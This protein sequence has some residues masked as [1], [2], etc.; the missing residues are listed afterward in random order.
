MALT[1]TPRSLTPENAQGSQVNGGGLSVSLTSVTLDAS[2]AANGVALSPQQMGFTNGVLGG[3][4]FVRTPAANI[5]GGVLDV[6]TNGTP[7]APKLKLMASAT[8]TVELG[9]GAGSGAVLD[10]LAV[11]F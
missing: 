9:N 3:I 6:T 5:S 4:A 11:G 10:V 7:A 1:Y 8:T 2:Y